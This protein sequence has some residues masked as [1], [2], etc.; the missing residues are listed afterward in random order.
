M[1]SGFPSAGPG[2][3]PC[4]ALPTTPPTRCRAHTARP[5]RVAPIRSQKALRVSDRGSQQVP[6]LPATVAR[7]GRWSGSSH[8]PVFSHRSGAQKSGFK[9][10]SGL[11][12]FEAHEGTFVFPLSWLR[13]I[14]WQMSVFLGRD[15]AP[16]PRPPHSHVFSVC[17]S[18]HLSPFW[19]LPSRWMRSSP[20]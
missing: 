14:C 10:S 2:C 4:P 8:R 6:W 1:G 15:A 5:I 19:G 16:Q 11:V 20:Y 3:S 9:V 17:V 7:Y 12:P 18:V 13:L